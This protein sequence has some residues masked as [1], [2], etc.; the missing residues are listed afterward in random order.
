MDNDDVSEISQDIAAAKPSAAS[1]IVRHIVARH[2]D[3]RQ[4]YLPNKTAKIGSQHCN[5]KAT[6]AM[7]ETCP[8]NAI[9]YANIRYIT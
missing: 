9:R 4:R 3:R 2:D 6:M 1:T 7:E 5:T 8:L